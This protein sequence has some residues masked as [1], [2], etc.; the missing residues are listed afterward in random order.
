MVAIGSTDWSSRIVRVTLRVLT[1]VI[2]VFAAAAFIELWNAQLLLANVGEDFAF[3]VSLGQRWLD[4]GVLYGD[5]QLTGLLY[6]VEINVDNLYPPPAVLLFAAFVF[7]PW[8]LWYLVP[9][10]LIAL[11]LWRTRPADW[12][13]PL[14][15]LC[16]LW[17]RTQGSFIVGNSDLWSAAFVA[18]GI[19][20]AWPSVLGLFKP[21]FAPFVLIGIRDRSWWIALGVALIVAV[22][23]A[24]YWPQYV[25]A[26]LNWDVP[27][28]RSL[29]N[30]PLLLIPVIAWLG[31][32]G[33]A[34]ARVTAS[35]PTAAR[36]PA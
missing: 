7:L 18:A 23:F 4:T 31:R 30:V 22:P 28:S 32:T 13:W 10:A 5:R 17:P 36:L 35:A 20:W 9:V 27:L 26:A 15:A 25:V 11:V 6:H 34:R 12:T 8:F 3:Y 19:L 21:A 2:L 1:G 14:I 16:L 29:A 33:A 24:G